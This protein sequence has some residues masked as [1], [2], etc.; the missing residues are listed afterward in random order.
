MKKDIIITY[1][2]A[3]KILLERMKEE[4]KKETM[5]DKRNVRRQGKKEITKK[6]R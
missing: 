4:T 6:R 1:G 5:K 3:I 2:K